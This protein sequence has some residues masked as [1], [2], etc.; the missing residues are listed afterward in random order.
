MS[1]SIPQYKYKLT[2]DYGKPIEDTFYN[3]NIKTDKRRT[4]AESAKVD[5]NKSNIYFRCEA[6][7]S[8]E[9]GQILGTY[10]SDI[11]KGH[12]LSKYTFKFPIKIKD[13]PIQTS[14]GFSLYYIN[15]PENNVCL[16]SIENR[17]IPRVEETQT[18]TASCTYG[19]VGS[20]SFYLF[21]SKRRLRQ[22]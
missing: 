3:F 9:V 18:I 6:Y 17:P 15:A 1:A 8:T 7:L 16:P 19:L 20:T 10:H 4:S 14:I 22:G 13:I 2:D 12:D 21:D 11:L 5:E